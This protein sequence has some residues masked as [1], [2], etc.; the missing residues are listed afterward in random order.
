MPYADY[1]EL[2]EF[3]AVEPWGLSVQD[4]MQAHLASIIANVNRDSKKRPDPY[5]LSEF[6]IF[7]TPQ[8]KPHTIPDEPVRVN[9]LTAAQHKLLMG[10]EALRQQLDTGKH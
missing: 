2:Q 7:S 5:Q 6:L 1:L 4:A 3:Y 10:F 9:G 8:Q